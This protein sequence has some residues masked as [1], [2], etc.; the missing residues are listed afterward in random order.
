ET[1]ASP[2]GVCI[3]AES[4]SW[5]FETWI[6]QAAYLPTGAGIRIVTPRGLHSDPLVFLSSQ[7]KRSTDG[8]P[9]H[10]GARRT[11]TRVTVQRAACATPISAG[12]RFLAENGLFSLQDGPTH[13]LELEWDHGREGK[14]QSFP[15]DV[16]IVVRW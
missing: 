3:R 4:R 8:S 13:H 12:V 14:S 2:F 1:G 5:P 15:A 7:A 6:Y 11:L 16:P 9:E 10:R